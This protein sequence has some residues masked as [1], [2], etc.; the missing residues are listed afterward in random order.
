MWEGLL[1][2]RRR[3]NQGCAAP[4]MRRPETSFLAPRKI[5]LAAKRECVDPNAIPGPE[6]IRRAA[7][8]GVQLGKDGA[9]VRKVRAAA[10]LPIEETATLA[11]AAPVNADMDALDGLLA[12][13]L[14]ARK[15]TLPARRALPL[16]PPPRPPLQPPLRRAIRPASGAKTYVPRSLSR[17]RCRSIIAQHTGISAIV[18][19]GTS[20]PRRVHPT[21][22]RRHR[23]ACRRSIRPRT[24]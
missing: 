12:S 14:R 5:A 24:R 9:L 19:Q 18:W 22:D 23:C 10:A 11:K 21:A 3:E 4:G 2:D 17:P 1:R 7:R 20:A 6:K 15:P 16:R 13:A 8:D